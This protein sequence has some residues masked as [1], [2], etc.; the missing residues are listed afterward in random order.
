L[1]VAHAGFAPA[2]SITQRTAAVRRTGRLSIIPG[3]LVV[4]AR[5]VGY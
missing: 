5:R 3:M 4:S 1:S 2:V